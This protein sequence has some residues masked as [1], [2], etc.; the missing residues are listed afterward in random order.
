MTQTGKA[1]TDGLSQQRARAELKILTFLGLATKAGK[2]VSGADAV[3]EA[4]ARGCAY[5]VLV[6]EDA[7]EG[8]AKKIAFFSR[9][10]GVSFCRFSTRQQLGKFLGKEDRAV[11][12][13]LDKGFADRLIQL[14]QDGFGLV[15]GE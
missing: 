2:T 13:V 3:A 7:S 12:A 4:V 5:L 1:E 14:L 6:T 11:A 10:A 9:Q 8:T 15:Q